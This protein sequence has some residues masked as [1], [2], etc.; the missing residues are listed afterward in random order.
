MSTYKWMLEQIDSEDES[1]K[2]VRSYI[3]YPMDD[4]S[5]IGMLKDILD[6]DSSYKSI[7]SDSVKKSLIR[8]LRRYISACSIAFQSKARIERLLKYAKSEIYYITT[9]NGKRVATVSEINNGAIGLELQSKD[10][11]PDHI[12]KRLYVLLWTLTGNPKHFISAGNK[13]DF[14]D[15]QWVVKSDYEMIKQ[16]ADSLNE[17]IS[18]F[19][20]DPD[21]FESTMFRLNAQYKLGT[22]KYPQSASDEVT[23][24]DTVKTML[25]RLKRGLQEVGFVDDKVVRRAYTLVNRYYEEPYKLKPLDIS[26]LR[27]VYN[28]IQ[29]GTYTQ[30]PV[31]TPNQKQDTERV[32]L[33]EQCREI[34]MGV[35][36]NKLSKNHFA[37][38]IIETIRKT[39]YSKCSDK[40]RSILDDAIRIIKAHEISNTN[41]SNKVNA[42][43]MIR[44]VGTIGTTGVEII[45]I[46]EVAR[47]ANGN[48]RL[49]RDSCQA[50]ILDEPNSSSNDLGADITDIEDL[51]KAL[52]GGFFG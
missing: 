15:K 29:D 5:L 46:D 34:E 42:S 12:R 22:Y 10:I 36:A 13:L 9:V 14:K 43:N 40:Q 48:Q 32:E 30:K 21:W 18:A 8:L 24:N 31:Q 37:L 6:D 7:L 44:T 38:K 1:D 11:I 16:C 19:E 51:S 47:A 41:S 20:Q 49:N 17:M 4:P 45:D 2:K 3:L 27:E 50:N 39:N 25:F 26:L 35:S 23:C 52:G 28:K 33:R